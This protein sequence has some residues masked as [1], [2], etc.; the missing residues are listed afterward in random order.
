[1]VNVT[2][3]Y[4]S[5]YYVYEHWID[6]KMFYVGKGTGVRAVDFKSR[7]KKWLE[8]V[9]GRFVEIKVNI[10]RHFDNEF[11]AI[12]Y[13]RI[14]IK[15]LLNLDVELTNVIYNLNKKFEEPNL[16]AIN[17]YLNKKLKVKDKINLCVELNIKD[18]FGNVKRW[19]AIKSILEESGYKLKNSKITINDKRV[20]VT[21][22][23]GEQE[24]IK[25][26]YK[27]VDNP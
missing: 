6:G 25:S 5:K 18:K 24:L 27:T 19:R 14:H 17:K 13:E 23:T 10:V 9:N 11:E 20:N 22:I 3:L 26:F 15:K 2:K 7:T 16:T 4:K 12:E 21:T 8:H 1:M